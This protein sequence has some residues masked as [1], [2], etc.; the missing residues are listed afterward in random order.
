MSNLQFT[1]EDYSDVMFLIYK[2]GVDKILK[3]KVKN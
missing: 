2:K 1:N 3:Q